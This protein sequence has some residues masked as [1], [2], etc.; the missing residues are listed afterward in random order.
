MTRRLGLAVVTSLFL[1]LPI[2]ARAAAPLKALIV[3]GQN[4][5]NW[6]ETTPILK[7]L[8]EQTKLFTVAV[9]TSPPKNA[10]MSGFKPSFAKY[11]VVVSNYNGDPWPAETNQ[12]LVRFVAGGGGLVSYHA[13]DNAFPKWEE[14]NKMIAIGGWGGRNEASGPYLRWRDGK[15][16]RVQ[17]PGRGGGHGPQHPFQIVVRDPDH[18]IMRGLPPVFMHASD[19]LYSW[20]R[21][22]AE[23]VDV[24]ATAFS[25]KKFR[26]SGE[27]EPMLMAIKYGKGRVFHT[28]LGHAKPQCHCVAFIVTFQRGTEWA[29]TG[30]VTQPIPDDFP[31]PDVPVVR[32][33]N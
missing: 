17:E 9:A 25:D 32:P 22:P 11:D 13:A 12:A 8:L 7:Q 24:L 5:H 30:N 29:A 14:Y 10:D 20:L 21:G 3:D 31:G 33:D 23:N 2:G 4:N 1:L 19:E 6:R 18:P 27:H 28:T 15:A 16:V 26:G